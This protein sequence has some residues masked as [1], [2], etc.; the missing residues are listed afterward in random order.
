[1]VEELKIFVD[2][3]DTAMCPTTTTT[4]TSTTMDPLELEDLLA[5][6]NGTELTSRNGT[7]VEESARPWYLVPLSWFGGGR[8]T[9]GAP[10]SIIICLAL[11]GHFDKYI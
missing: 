9:G 5:G 11:G 7:A 10:A 4:T 6:A 8:A 2:I 3:W 1:M